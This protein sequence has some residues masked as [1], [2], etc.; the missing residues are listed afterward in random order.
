[1]RRRSETRQRLLHAAAELFESSGTISQRIEEICARAGFTRGAF[2]S[3][4]GGVDQLYLALH[5]EQAARVWERLHAAIAAQLTA[6]GREAT[7]DDAVRV[8]L[9]A[10]PSDREWFSLRSVLLARATADPAFATRMTILD[11]PVA[12]ALG[13]R[14]GALAAVHGRV[15]VVDAPVLAK[16]VVAAH[17][18]TVSQ[19]PVD[20]DAAVTQYL[21]VA[22]VLR[23]LTA[24]A[25]DATAAADAPSR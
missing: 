13:E 18:G 4:F 15:P 1:M 7:L 21:T 19:W 25:G 24:E 5:E 9:D 6:D 16:A 23:G 3:N 12:R 11:D 17:V 14:L 22:A 8:L 2:Y 20:A 10:L